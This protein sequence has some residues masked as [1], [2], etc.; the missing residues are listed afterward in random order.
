MEFRIT[1]NYLV[2][3]LTIL[4]LHPIA[5]SQ[6]NVKT[7]LYDWFDNAIGKENLN[8]NNGPLHSNPYRTITNKNRY[9]SDEFTIGN[10]SFENQIYFDVKLKY[11]ILEDQVVFKLNQQ[12]DNL[13]INLIRDKVDY[14]YIRNKKFINLS[15]K[16]DNLPDFIKGYYEENFVGNAMELYIKHHKDRKEIYYFDGF[17]SDYIENNEFI[18]KYKNTF[19]KIDSEKEI[20][21]LFPEYKKAISTFYS[22][23][24]AIEKSDKKQFMEN[25]IKQ[26]DSFS[27]KNLK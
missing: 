2:S 11:D 12:T 26:M 19:I 6:T 27:Y 4:L 24:R 8:I 17:Y 20:K 22:I 18:L 16:S 7:N 9:Y 15:S 10:I 14:F 5:H 21:Q 1:A 13:A 3:F 25:L 23:N